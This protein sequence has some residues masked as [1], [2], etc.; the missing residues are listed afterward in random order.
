ME[1]LVA[2]VLKKGTKGQRH[3]GTKEEV[4]GVEGWSW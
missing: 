4:G 2:E 1:K 3:R